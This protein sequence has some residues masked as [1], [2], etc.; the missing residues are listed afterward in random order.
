MLTRNGGMTVSDGSGRFV[1]GNLVI[2]LE[3]ICVILPA[4]FLPSKCK[5]CVELHPQS[6]ETNCRHATCLNMILHIYL[7]EIY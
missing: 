5:L 1:I 2:V 7:Y 6:L 3:I 4:I